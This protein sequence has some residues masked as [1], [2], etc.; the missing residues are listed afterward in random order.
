L[1]QIAGAIAGVQCRDQL[2]HGKVAAAS[3]QGEIE[4]WESHDS[5]P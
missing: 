4:I 2:A 3:E 5:G 1:R